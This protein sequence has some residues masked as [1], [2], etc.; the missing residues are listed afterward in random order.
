LQRN[1][2]IRTGS[3]QLGRAAWVAALGV[4]VGACG[5]E[6]GDP[7]AELT[8]LLRERTDRGSDPGM[9]LPVI[10][11]LDLPSMPAPAAEMAPPARTRPLARDAMTIAVDQRTLQVLDQG[12]RAAFETAGGV[13]L[14]PVAT[15]D[16][17]GLDLLL[18][19]DADLAL[20]TGTLSARELQ[21]GLRQSQLGVELFALVVPETSPVQ[22]LSRPQLR[23]LLLGEVSV[24]SS[25][26]HDLGPI[27][28]V[29]P[30]DRDL[31]ARAGQALLGGPITAP[32]IKVQDERYLADQ[33][34]RTPGAIGVVRVGI[35]RRD[36]RSKLLPIDYTEPTV[37]AW[38][39]GMYPFGLPVQLVTNG[40]VMGAAQRMVV[41]AR[42]DDGQ[43]LLTGLGGVPGSARSH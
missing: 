33:L 40:P 30:A 35:E 5:G 36:P 6:P 34:L 38:Q 11:G 29:V 21:A 14:T 17:D 27:N 42:T 25:F 12:W 7:R 13:A 3:G 18:L 4:F 19:G 8:E 20:F 16:R 9:V 26:G 10:A 22:S 2:T 24:W 1:S 39:Q 31:F 41:F 15:N 37:P 43:R 32:A 28:L 23:Q